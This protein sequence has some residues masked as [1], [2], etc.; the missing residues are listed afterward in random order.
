MGVGYQLVSGIPSSGPL[1]PGGSV[2]ASAQQDT[3]IA[4]SPRIVPPI[5]S[6]A[7]N[8][9]DSAATVGAGTVVNLPGCTV[10]LGPAS[11]GVINT[12]ELMIDGI[13]VSTLV[14]WRVSIN[15]APVQGW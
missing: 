12:L 9:A 13:V 8:V 1:T 5:N 2:L 15:G 6:L 7:I 10:T 3:G 11:Q 4:L 14:Y